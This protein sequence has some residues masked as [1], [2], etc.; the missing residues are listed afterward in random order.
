[1]TTQAHIQVYIRESNSQQRALM[2]HQAKYTHG[3][4]LFNYLIG[5]KYAGKMGKDKTLIVDDGHF[6]V[7]DVVE[8]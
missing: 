5:G 8:R 3:D 6:S 7:V 4:L 2:I 1:M